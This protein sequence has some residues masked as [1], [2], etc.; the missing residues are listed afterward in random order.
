M[1]E[2]LK[3]RHYVTG[4][5]Y[6]AGNSSVQ[7]MSSRELAAHFGIARSTVS[8]ALKEL[9]E[10]G[11]LIAKHGIGNFTNPKKLA[12][13]KE[14][15]M[16][17]LIGVIL[18]N[19]RD[20]YIS[21]SGWKS[22]RATGDAIIKAG[23]CLRYLQLSGK[24][25]DEIFEEIMDSRLDA[26]IWI[27]HLDLTEALMKRLAG[28]GLPVICD[29]MGFTQVN[30]AAYD[31]AAACYKI[32]KEFVEKNVSAIL[33]CLS[34]WFVEH[35]LPPIGKAY[36]NAEKECRITIPEKMEEENRAFFEEYFRKEKKGVV[37]ANSIFHS[38]FRRLLKETGAGF[39]IFDR[40]ET[41]SGKYV[42]P[43]D[44]RARIMLARLKGLINGKQDIEQ[45][46]IPMK[47]IKHKKQ[48]EMA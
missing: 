16:P 47:F 46:P 5:M 37:I 45:I 21:D 11:F 25:E 13:P 17:V 33:Y 48:K 19:G 12:M 44:E 26:L 31:T 32:G 28:A 7:I 39:L 2:T 15:K 6:H 20:F 9:T 24:N 42:F 40:L 3:I 36:R 27:D 35:D 4:I 43:H 34:E 29:N 10:E 23:Y 41:F 14:G 22:L 1:K 30:T 8:L 18:E 38:F